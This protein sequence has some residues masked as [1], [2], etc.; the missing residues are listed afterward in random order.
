MSTIDSNT[1]LLIRAI[2]RSDIYLL[3]IALHT[4]ISIIM[5][6]KHYRKDIHAI[7]DRNTLCSLQEEVAL[8]VRKVM[9]Y[10]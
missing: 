3:L 1:V 8:Y 4:N 2:K 5:S 9:W 6:D 7:L 10:R